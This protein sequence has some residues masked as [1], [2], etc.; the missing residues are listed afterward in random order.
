M[1][2]DI[3]ELFRQDLNRAID[4]TLFE[5]TK[6]EAIDYF[7]K[8]VGKVVDNK[9][10]DKLGR[11]KIRVFGLFSDKIDDTDLPWATPDMDFVGSKVGSFVVP[12]VDT[13]V[14]VY[15]NKGDIYQPHYTTKTIDKNNLSSQKDTD[16]PD[17]MVMY[18][19]DNGDY[20]TINRKSKETTFH[21]SSGAEIKID[22]LGNVNVKASATGKYTLHGVTNATELAAPGPGPFCALPSCLY[23]GALH[24]S[25][26]VIGNIP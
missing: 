4:D 3:N 10:P 8:F 16:Y 13:I 12:P 17:N 15:F 19:T 20:L 14:N 9:D 1:I 18:E 25:N 23:T 26:N 7:N 6:E 22:K 5:P 24:T 2:K 11:C 21:H